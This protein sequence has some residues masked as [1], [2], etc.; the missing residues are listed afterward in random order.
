MTSTT[1]DANRLMNK[2]LV[3]IKLMTKEQLADLL[4]VTVRTVYRKWQAG[5]IPQPVKIG[6]LVRWTSPSILEW[7]ENGCPELSH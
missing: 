6:K 3:P 2:E 1:I 5:E 7:I 4:G